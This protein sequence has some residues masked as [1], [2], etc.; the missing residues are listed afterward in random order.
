MAKVMERA[1][2]WQKA[3]TIS[4]TPAPRKSLGKMT[5]ALR[6]VKVAGLGSLV[7]DHT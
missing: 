3:A 1:S 4:P 2:S 7:D 5:I 6:N